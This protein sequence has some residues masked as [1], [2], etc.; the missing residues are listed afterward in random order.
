M[1]FFKKI[2]LTV[3]ASAD[4]FAGKIEN[5]EAI[6]DGIIKEVEDALVN[7]RSELL[8][9]RNEVSRLEKTV[10]QQRKEKE[11]WTERAKKTA[12]SDR[13][14]ALQCVRFIKTSEQRIADNEQELLEISTVEKELLLNLSEGEKRL[15]ELRRKKRI[16]V[17]RQSRAEASN[18]AKS[19][20]GN[21]FGEADDLFTRWEAKVGRTEGIKDQ[22][23]TEEELMALEFSSEEE[24]DELND[25]L[26]DLLSKPS[27]ENK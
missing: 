13:E 11:R 26:N 8:K 10:N 24:K 1:N 18:M 2:W 22:S 16:L 14:K 12:E 19:A 20:G 15:S 9:T 17:S 4:S 3:G 21:I 7:V 23:S 25:L 27:T 6:A 5:Q